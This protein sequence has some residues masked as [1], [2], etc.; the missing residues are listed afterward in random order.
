MMPKES[1]LC[2][3]L[4]LALTPQSTPRVNVVLTPVFLNQVRGPPG[5]RG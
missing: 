1:M 3:R 5:H 4:P 2:A